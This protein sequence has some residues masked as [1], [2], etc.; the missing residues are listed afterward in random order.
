MIPPIAAPAIVHQIE[1][2]P[3]AAS[4]AAVTR[5]VPEGTGIPHP[6][7]IIARATMREP[8]RESRSV[9]ASGTRGSHATSGALCRSSAV[10]LA[11]LAPRANVANTLS[12]MQATT[13]CVPVLLLASTLATSAVPV[14]PDGT[15]SPAAVEPSD[16]AR[17]TELPVPGVD[18]VRVFDTDTRD[19]DAR[20]VRTI[21]GPHTGLRG[22]ADVAVDSTGT[23][24][25]ANFAGDAIT[26]YAPRANGD[27]RPIRTITGPHTK[28]HGPAS[29]AVDASG[30]LYVVDRGFRV[31]VYAPGADGDVA[32]SRIVAGS[33]TELLLAIAVAVDRAGTMFVVVNGK[34]VV[35]HAP[36]ANGNTTP[37][38]RLGLAWTPLRAG[39]DLF[40]SARDVAI[41]RGDTLFVTSG[42][43]VAVFAPGVD[44]TPRPLRRI[45]GPHTGLATPTAL[46]VDA[47]GVF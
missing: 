16:T 18:T 38:R 45:A 27:A 37:I 33:R 26:V 35:V 40:G 21:A 25:V 12:M 41:G 44:D 2:V 14:R 19:A 7:R 10:H 30:A 4:A 17:R 24:Y 8:Y 34:G 23:L 13:S 20:P 32:P 9:S 31:L 47:R 15:T 11:S 3:R 28:L 42:N 46:G 22:P 43:T 29:V 6:S 5:I 1:S 39:L 36:G